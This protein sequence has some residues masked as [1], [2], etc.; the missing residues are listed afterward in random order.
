M[1]GD[2]GRE[3]T[4]GV[5]VAACLAAGVVLGLVAMTVKGSDPNHTAFDT[6]LSTTTGF[7]YLGAGATAHARRPTNRA[8]L[9]MA[10]VGLL[11][12]TEDLKLSTNPVLFTLGLLF[13]TASGPGIV[14]L[15]LAFPDGELKSRWERLL[16]V[17]TYTVS[18]GLALAIMLVGDSRGLSP[19]REPNLLLIT[20]DDG[21]AE[22]FDRCLEGV[23]ALIAAGVITVLVYRW[24]TGKLPQRRLLTP[25]LVV[26][27]TGACLSVVG[28][29]AGA[30]GGAG[31][32]GPVIRTIYN[33]VFCLWPLAFLLG[34]LRARIGSAELARLLADR[35]EGRLSALVKDD[36]V[37][38][39][40]HS[41]N[42]LTAAAG[43]V[44]DNQRLAAELEKQLAEV[45]ESR[46]RIVSASDNE[47]RRVERDL[48]DGAQQ[49]LVSVLLSVR[50][51]RQRLGDS[52]TPELDEVL[53]ATAAELQ[54]A[55]T[56]L[57]ELARGIRP[58][59]LTEDGLVPAIRSLAERVPLIIQLHLGE[60]PR[61]PDPVELTAYF[62]VSES[63]TNTLKH[64]RA[65]RVSIE[66]VIDNGVLRLE[67]TDDGVGCAELSADGTGLSNLRDRVRALDG[68]LIVH[69]AVKAGT[70]VLAVIPLGS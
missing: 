55:I 35:D 66:V 25:V 7:V 49:R 45:R 70:S 15:V 65:S 63:L 58:R 43:L 27:L 22:L 54:V 61:L 21:L 28:N 51:A 16:V 33:L 64:A 40:S 39:D 42:A 52:L 67:V 24:V 2:G 8:G 50:M 20:P 30:N 38:Q 1:P 23:G 26:A 34:V 47:R 9:L 46:A 6:A 62:V 59:I 57:R 14:H 41:Y 69:S 37:W 48:H 11:F 44:R 19:H 36:A 3:R 31:P 10:W 53:T 5:L 18:F 68:E 13:S 12:F 29:L 17:A 32:G 4:H 56:E 60:I